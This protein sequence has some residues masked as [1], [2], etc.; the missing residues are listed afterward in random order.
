MRACVAQG[1][2]GI[3][4]AAALA[5]CGNGKVI[6][7]GPVPTAPPVVPSVTFEYKVPTPS[8]SPAGIVAGRDGFLYFAEMAASK[9]GQ[10]STGGA[11]AEIKT[12]TPNA[13]PAFV[14]VGPDGA[15]WFTEP[16]VHRI[17]TVTAFSS[18]STTEYLVPWAN[19]APAFFANGP[20]LN[21]MYFTDPGSGSV[22]EITTTGVVSGPFTLSNPAATPLGIAQGP[23]SNMWFCESG[24]AKIGHLNTAANVIDH[25][26]ALA[27][28]SNPWAIVQGPDGAMWFTEN[29]STAPKLGRLTTSGVLNEYPLA[30]AKSAT[31]LALDLFGNFDVL[32]ASNNAV[33]QFNVNSLKYTEY[34]I[35]TANA[36]PVWITLGPDGKMYFTEQAANQIGQLTYF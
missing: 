24:A 30:G 13:G 8:A 25:E 9:I 18:G 23:D 6:G 27:P 2:I 3:L 20:G 7:S 15:I 33:G 29:S 22:G 17:A 16:A 11:F 28:G 14:A 12:K 10:L 5:G 21:T 19:A 31:G 36:K 34:P 26:Y 32:D 4:C 1:A 35:K